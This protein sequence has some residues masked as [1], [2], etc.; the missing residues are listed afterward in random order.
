MQILHFSKEYIISFFQSTTFKYYISK[1]GGIGVKTY[2]DFADTGGVGV[3]NLENADVILECFL[4]SSQQYYKYII[5]LSKTIKIRV[6][7]VIQT[8]KIEVWNKFPNLKFFL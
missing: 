6:I 1:L 7:A 4:R 5:Q 3:Q 2:P 8:L